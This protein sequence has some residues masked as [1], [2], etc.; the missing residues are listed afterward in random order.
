MIKC[1]FESNW[2]AVYGIDLVVLKHSGDHSAGG[3]VR[4]FSAFLVLHPVRYYDLS[5]VSVTERLCGW[6]KNCFLTNEY[7]VPC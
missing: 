6:W 1:L 4:T 2:V 7:I 3:N 5:Q